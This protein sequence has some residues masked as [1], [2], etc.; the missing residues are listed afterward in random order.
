MEVIDLTDPIVE[1]Q[2]TEEEDKEV[3]MMLVGRKEPGKEVKKDK[4]IKKNPKKVLVQKKRIMNSEVDTPF[5]R[6]KL[7]TIDRIRIKFN[8]VSL[9]LRF[10]Q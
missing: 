9:Q 10:I 3:E 5:T 2:Y 4:T 1:A 6:A 8:M 7:L